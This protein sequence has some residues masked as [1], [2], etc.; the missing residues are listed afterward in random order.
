MTINGTT[1]TIS[2]I[3]ITAIAVG[4][5]VWGL[6]G[7]SE[8]LERVV[9]DVAEVKAAGILTAEGLTDVEKAVI[10]IQSNISHM[11]EDI[12]SI[13]TLQKRSLGIP[14]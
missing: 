11:Q 4:G 7:R 8:D 12:A 14:E 13:L 5:L 9:E 1:K 2:L 3:I 6:S 10:L